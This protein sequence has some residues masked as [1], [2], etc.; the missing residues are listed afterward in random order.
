MRL[1]SRERIVVFLEEMHGAQNINRALVGLDLP[2][3]ALVLCGGLADKHKEPDQ[4]QAAKTAADEAPDLKFAHETPFKTKKVN[5]VN[6][7]A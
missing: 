4:K 3:K 1:K 6:T 2:Q 5:A 7:R